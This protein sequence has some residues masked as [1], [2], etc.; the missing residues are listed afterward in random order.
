MN[1]NNLNELMK[2]I[3]DNDRHY[4]IALK[5]YREAVREDSI[6]LVLRAQMLNA[7]KERR[8]VLRV[9]HNNMTR[10]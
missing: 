5:D 8:D 6:F 7:V 9:R 2:Q 4:E 10:K 1:S 3:R